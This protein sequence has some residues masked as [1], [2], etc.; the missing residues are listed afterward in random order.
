MEDKIC[1]DSDFLIDLLRNKKEVSEWIKEKED[2]AE[3]STTIINEYEL[4]CG[5]Y[6]SSRKE[7]I[8][9]IEEVMKTLNVLPLTREIVKKAGKVTAD[10]AK[11]GNLIDFRDILIGCIAESNNNSLKTNNKKH[12]ERIP[13]LKLV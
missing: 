1:L 11:T 10:L 2:S 4:Y 7:S 5:A 12:F 3:L 9:E 6:N 8:N 13:G